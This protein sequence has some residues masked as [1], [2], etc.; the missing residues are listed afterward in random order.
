MGMMPPH[1]MDGGENGQDRPHGMP[2]WM[3]L[4]PTQ[5]QHGLPGFQDSVIS[6]MRRNDG[7]QMG[8]DIFS[9]GSGTLGMPPHGQHGTNASF[10]GLGMNMGRYQGSGGGQGVPGDLRQQLDQEGVGSRGGGGGFDFGKVFG[11]VSCGST[12]SAVQ[13]PMP[14]KV[15]SLAGACRLLCNSFEYGLCAEN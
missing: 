9:H 14:G 15:M 11:G 10:E 5:Q 4:P 12:G 1:T 8:G 7:Q 2:L 13:M 6:N 3:Q